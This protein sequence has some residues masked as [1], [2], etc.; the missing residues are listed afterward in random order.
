[1]TLLLP[2]YAPELG[3][4]GAAGGAA[5]AAHLS[6]PGPQRWRGS[7]KMPP[8]AILLAHVVLLQWKQWDGSA[9]HS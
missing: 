1:M 3:G 7:K 4:V 6:P 9:V 8:S 2:T 5:C